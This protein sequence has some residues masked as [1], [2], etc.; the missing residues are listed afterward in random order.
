M[1]IDRA[2]I[3]VK[4][5]KGGNGCISFRREKYV[6]RG[7]PDGGNGGLGGTVILE[8]SD[9]LS[10]LNA[11]R[12]K[13][14]FKAE[15]GRHG[16]GKQKDG[17]SGKDLIVKVPCGTQIYDEDKISLLADLK[18]SGERFAAARGGGGGRGNTSFTTST[19]QAPRL[20]EPG[21]EGEEFFLI[22]E[23]KLIAD[24]GLIGYP[25]S[26]KSTLIS[27]ISS[28]RP[29]IADYPFTT[30]TPH[31]GVVSIGDYDS[32]TIADIPGLIEGAHQGHGLGLQ[33]LRHVERTRLLLHLVEISE[34]SGRD[35]LKDIKV[36]NS[37]LRK[38]SPALS[39]KP[40]IIVASKIDILQQAKRLALIKKHC[41]KKKLDLVPISSITGKGL[42]TLT[43]LAHRTLKNLSLPRKEGKN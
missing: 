21:K 39:R 13:H 1:F 34:S 38:Y 18:E 42:K 20:S 32:F 28:A 41:K 25:N 30:L 43:R 3:N 26:G 11:F 9:S 35:P 22:L 40:Q 5:G 19:R 16:Q 29:K 14:H 23:L 27:K 31:L 33:F 36:I 24:V 7:G 17:K 15:R 10:T 2:K 6:P 4:G 12:F 8:A 37:E